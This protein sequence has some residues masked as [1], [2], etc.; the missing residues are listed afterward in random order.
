[1][2]CTCT[3]SNLLYSATAAPS[4]YIRE[5]SLTHA[6]DHPMEVGHSFAAL[7]G[8]SYAPD[9]S[10]IEIFL[11]LCRVGYWFGPAPG[12]LLALYPECPDD[13]D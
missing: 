8:G 6:L 5:S 7:P 13:F 12:V 2:A 11:Y 1:M 3:I 10:I 4:K 9:G